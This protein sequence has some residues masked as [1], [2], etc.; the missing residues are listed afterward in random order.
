MPSLGNIVALASLINLS[1]VGSHLSDPSSNLERIATL[2]HGFDLWK[3][4]PIFGAGLGSFNFHSLTWF[5][6]ATVIHSTPLWL[7]AELGLV[8]FTLVLWP[9]WFAWKILIKHQQDV[10][11]RILVSLIISVAVFAQFHEIFYQRIIWLVLG[12]TLAL[13]I[14]SIKSQLDE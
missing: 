2:T 3:N 11:S 1:S 10:N 14:V 7:L 6:H 4:N 12:A 8:G 5:G 9:L 13:P